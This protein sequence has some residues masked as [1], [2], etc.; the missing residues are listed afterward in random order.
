MLLAGLF[1]HRQVAQPLLVAWT[2]A[3]GNWIGNHWQLLAVII[4][5]VGA[6]A[7]AFVNHYLALARDARARR[8]QRTDAF[9]RV[10][11]ELAARLI[12]HAEELRAA[13]NDPRAADLAGLRRTNDA[14]TER[15][16]N[17]EVVQTLGTRYVAFAGALDRERRALARLDGEAPERVRTICARAVLE[18]VPFIAEFGEGARA[19]PLRAF[20][21]P[22]R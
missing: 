22:Y 5:V 21:E 17:D 18:F 10:R 13:A 4:P 1:G 20:A 9:A 7:L 11:K 16:R 19:L 14:L 3:L 8:L 2:H 15:S 6:I 12:V